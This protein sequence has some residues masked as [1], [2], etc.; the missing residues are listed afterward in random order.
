MMIYHPGGIISFGSAD[1]VLPQRAT[2]DINPEEGCQF[3]K[4]QEP[5]SQRQGS[6]PQQALWALSA[7]I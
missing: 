6:S 2:G 5:T 4:G 7:E 1:A 3:I